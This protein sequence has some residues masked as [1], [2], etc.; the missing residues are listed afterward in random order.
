MRGL[1]AE[2]GVDRLANDHERIDL[3]VEI[4]LTSEWQVTCS[5]P[6]GVIQS[7]QPALA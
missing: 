7:P 3:G 1:V 2:R 5:V 4:H 6:G